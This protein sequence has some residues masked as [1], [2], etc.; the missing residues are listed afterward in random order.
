MTTVHS[1]SDITKIL[2]NVIQNASTL[3]DVRVQGEVLGNGHPHAFFLINGKD[4]LRC[5]I[6]DGNPAKFPLLKQ[7]NAVVVNGEIT[8]FPLPNQYQIKVSNIQDTEVHEDGVSVTEITNQIS[9]LVAETPELQDIRIQ[10][11][12]L[13]VF[14]TPSPNWDLCNVDG[15]TELQIKCVCPRAIRPPVQVGN[16][17]CVRG[18]VSINPFRSEFQINVTDA[19]PIPKCQCP[20][21]E[22]CCHPP[23][24]KCN[25]IRNPKYE[26]C[27]ACYEISPD[28]EKNVKAA[29][30]AYFSDLKV[31]GFSPSR[32]SRIQFGS[33]NGYADVVLT[34]GNG[35]FA[36]I[37]ECKGAGYVG[38]GRE[39][40]KSYLSATDTQFGIFANRVDSKQW[41]FYENLRRNRFEEITR[42][43]FETR[44]DESQSLEDYRNQLRDEIEALETEI[45]QKKTL[46]RQENQNI[47]ALGTEKTQLE[48]EVAELQR[49]ENEL[50]TSHQQRKE[51]IAQLE[52]LVNDLKSDLLDLDTADPQRPRENKKQGI[53]NWLKNLFSKENE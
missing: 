9:H 39:Q 53:L 34:N 47:D 29:V 14:Q 48:T 2:S 30:E 12:V 24:T 31:N 46:V 10:G 1:V 4:R 33:N 23:G 8:L 17:V 38:H 5:F 45:V 51:K 22:G 40:L 32:E 28:H 43:D 26:L 27:P 52:T 37:A 20:G 16:N 3:Q 36:V 6:P 25:Q 21:Y 11:K 13:R 18:D 41:E 44:V 35:T 19:G 7:G 42:S 15:S 50:H 49:K